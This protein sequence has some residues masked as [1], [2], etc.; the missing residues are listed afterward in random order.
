[1][2]TTRPTTTHCHSTVALQLA[3]CRYRGV[4]LGLWNASGLTA[5]VFAD[6]LFLIGQ[7]WVTRALDDE[8][9]AAE[10][11][12]AAMALVPPG[13]VE[14]ILGMIEDGDLPEPHPDAMDDWLESCRQAGA[15]DFRLT[16]VRVP[17]APPRPQPPALP[18][19]PVE[20]EAEFLVRLRRVRLDAEAR[21]ADEQARLARG[22]RR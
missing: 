8:R 22:P 3:Q 18:P 2:Q 1:M 19:R 20:S 7:A 10:D 6:C 5:P 11:L 9:G 21:M 15:G 12:A 17:A 14:M 16:F 4:I 13:T